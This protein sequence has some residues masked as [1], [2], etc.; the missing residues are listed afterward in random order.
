MD[1]FL[2]RR[3]LPAGNFWLP[4]KEAYYRLRL[5]NLLMCEYGPP[6]RVHCQPLIRLVECGCQAGGGGSMDPQK[7]FDEPIVKHHFSGHSCS[8]LNRLP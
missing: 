8:G 4:V 3:P 1:Q 7:M 5:S 2:L 6:M